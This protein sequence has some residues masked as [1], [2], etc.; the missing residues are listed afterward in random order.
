MQRLAE[1]ATTA[2]SSRSASLGAL[3]S[4]SAAIV[5]IVSALNR[6][7]DIEE[8]AAV[9]EGPTGGARSDAWRCRIR[10]GGSR[11]G[12]GGTNARAV[13]RRFASASA[14]PFTWTWLV[15]QWPLAFALVAT[16]LGIDLLLR[17]RRGSGLGVDHAGSDRG[18]PPLADCLD[19]VQALYRQVH[20]LQR[21]IRQRRRRHR[22]CS[23]GSTCQASRFSPGRSSTPRL[24]M[25]R[26]TAR[27]R[28]R[29]TP[30]ET[31]AG[32]PS[33]PPLP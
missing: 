14:P 25:P 30:P 12:A 28:G 4:S 20:R 16:A 2:A 9:V 17:T 7:Y 5:S 22:R 3:W 18:H 10:A 31:D 32:P 26:R 27:P 6:A 1:S 19:R 11:A 13:R 8:G 29:R 23:C 33:G 15:V 24:S 21:R